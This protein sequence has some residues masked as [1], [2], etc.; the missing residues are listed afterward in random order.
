MSENLSR[1]GIAYNLNFS[2]YKLEVEYGVDHVVY[3]FSSELYKQKFKDK[4]E[5]NRA[6]IS[7]SLS[8]RFGFTITNDILADLKLYSQT[9]KRGFLLYYNEKSFE[10]LNT[11]ALNGVTMTYKN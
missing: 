2:P 6:K 4:L 7:E 1:N 11:T 10:W 8:K 3:V 9:E 5:E